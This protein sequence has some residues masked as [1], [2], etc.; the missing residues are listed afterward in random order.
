MRDV[1]RTRRRHGRLAHV[2]A[3]LGFALG[4]VACTPTPTP[5][6]TT[7]SPTASDAPSPTPQPDP[8]PDVDPSEPH[9][10]ATVLRWPDGSE[11]D[12]TALDTG[13]ARRASPGALTVLREIKAEKG[14]SLNILDVGADGAVLVSE[15]R[16]PE[17]RDDGSVVPGSVVPAVVRVVDGQR[18]RVLASRAEHPE[19]VYLG[20]LAADGTAVWFGTEI[21]ETSTVE[22]V[23]VYRAPAGSARGVEIDV[24]GDV[25]GVFDDGVVLGDGSFLSWDGTT[26]DLKL[27]AISTGSILPVVC[28]RDECPRVLTEVDESDGLPSVDVPVMSSTRTV[29]SYLEDGAV[30]P[31]LRIEGGGWVLAA[32]ESWLVVAVYGVD[33]SSHVWLVDTENRRARRLVDVS[34]VALAG[35]RVVWGASSSWSTDVGAEHRGLGDLHVLDLATG[36]LVRIVVGEDVVWPVAEGGVIAWARS[37]TDGSVSRTGVVARLATDLS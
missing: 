28:E 3:L 35:S 6:P 5:A 14:R 23:H 10:A 36:D 32:Y 9:L 19:D 22:N 31:A 17:Y 24:P 12:G 26:Q 16:E 18:D 30:T 15:R 29:V 2:C 11:V 4:L 20:R 27:P 25:A 8:P 33:F 13:T 21:R 37:N 1:G 34:G 7:S